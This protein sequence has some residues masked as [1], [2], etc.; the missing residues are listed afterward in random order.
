MNKL[1]GVLPYSVCLGNHDLFTINI[2]NDGW[3]YYSAFFGATHFADYSWFGGTNRQGTSSYQVFEADGRNWLHLNMEYMPDVESLQWAQR[4][5]DAHPD[6]PAIY[7]THAY[8]TDAAEQETIFDDDPNTPGWC[9][10]STNT[11]AN[12][13][14][15]GQWSRLIA[16]NDQIFM[17]FAAIH[18]E[19]I[20]KV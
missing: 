20:M 6:M 10:P 18:L 12:I 1:D 9:S 4:V 16:N 14:G 5:L 17:F 7:S 3:F 19:L 8:I 13:G 2:K 11:I 15:N